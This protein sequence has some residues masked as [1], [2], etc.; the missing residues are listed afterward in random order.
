MP[1]P[2]LE[3]PLFRFMTNEDANAFRKEI[4]AAGL[5]Y[6]RPICWHDQAKTFPKEIV[7][8]S[9]F[10]LRFATR[11]VG[12]TAAHVVRKFQRAKA[13][14]PSLVC[15]LHL[16]LFD[17]DGALIDIDDDLDIATFAISEWQLNKTLTDPFDVSTR[18]PLDD[19]VKPDASIQ[20]V[21]YPENIRVINS[22]E[23]SAV[24]NAWGALDFIQD[25]NEREIILTYEPDKVLGAPTKPPLGYNM[26]G[27]SGGPGIVHELRA[28][29]LHVWYPV[30]LIVEGPRFGEGDSAAFDI[31]RVRRI[32]FVQADGH[33]RREMGW[34]PG[35]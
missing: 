8:A 25:Y 10:V 2:T 26:S 9:C 17:L 20:L 32:D 5:R 31:I 22:I 28:S 23:K 12:V 35:R 4:A 14:S 19:V 33:I 21:G 18:W 24:F 6:A 13:S 11:L 1:R 3:N 16:M 34:L 7:G 15:Q 30:G 29:N 27:C